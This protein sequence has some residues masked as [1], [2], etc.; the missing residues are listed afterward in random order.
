MRGRLH[1]KK[2]WVHPPPVACCVKPSQ[3]PRPRGKRKSV[4]LEDLFNAT[5][6]MTKKQHQQAK[7]TE[8][9]GGRIAQEIK[10]HNALAVDN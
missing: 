6:V 10:R 8:G 9:G 2:K 1:N 5:I 4:S 7:L 3:C